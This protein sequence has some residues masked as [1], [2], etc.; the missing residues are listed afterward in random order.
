[1]QARDHPRSSRALCALLRGCGVGRCGTGLGRSLRGSRNP[2]RE[3]GRPYSS[4][5]APHHPLNDGRTSRSALILAAEGRTVPHTPRVVL[6]AAGRPVASGV[7]S[8][9]RGSH[10]VGDLLQHGPRCRDHAAASSAPRS[11][12]G[13][14]LSDIVVPIKAIGIDVEIEPGV[15]P[16]I[17]EPFRTAADVEG[18]VI[19]SQTMWRQSSRQSR[20]LPPSWAIRR[21]SVCRAPFTVASYL[22]EGRPSRDHIHTKALM[23]SDPRTWNLLLDRIASICRDF[24]KLQIEV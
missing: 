7:P 5:T 13:N 12:R 23:L 17:A 19:L 4:G 21:S 15:G 24:L 11:R 8:S 20:R 16:V 3:C 6:Y 2:F 22:V 10:D 14:L 9:A 18:F 1:M